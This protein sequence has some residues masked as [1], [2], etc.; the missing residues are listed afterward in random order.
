MHDERVRLFVALELPATVR[1]SLISWREEAVGRIRDLRRL[2]ADSM[3]VTLCFLGWREER[4][5]EPIA[6]ACEVLSA[7]RAPRLSLGDP[8]WLPPRRPRVLAVELHDPGGALTSAQSALSETLAAGGWYQPEKRPYLAHVT[9]ARVARGGRVPR[10]ALSALPSLEFRGE[11]V[12][13][14]RSRLFRSGARY[15]PLATVKLA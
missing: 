5:V 7:Q 2:S 9:V 13:L 8:C 3:H 14:F 11:R 12:T 4:E 10:G 1:D 6:A 15:E